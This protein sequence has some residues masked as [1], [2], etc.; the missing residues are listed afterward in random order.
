MTGEIQRHPLRHEIFNVEIP[1]P[2][3]VIPRVGANVPHSSRRAAVQRIRKAIQPVLR[4]TDHSTDYL[5]VRLN[6]FQLHRLIGQRLAVTVAQQTIEDHRLAG[7]IQIAR[8]KHKKL[9]AVTGIPG[10]IEFR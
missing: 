9:L 10:D 1:H 4:L 6:H 8:A 3:L 2:G 7:T 5:T